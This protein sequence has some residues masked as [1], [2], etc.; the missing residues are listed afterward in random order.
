MNDRNRQ[1]VSPFFGPLV[2]KDLLIELSKGLNRRI[3]QAAFF[4][5]EAD[6]VGDFFI[7]GD[8]GHLF[9]RFVAGLGGT[10]MDIMAFIQNIMKGAEIADRVF[11]MIIAKIMQCLGSDRFRISIGLINNKFLV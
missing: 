9:E 7:D 8:H 2:C 1:S 10:K 3:V 4:D 6:L 11:D 5:Q